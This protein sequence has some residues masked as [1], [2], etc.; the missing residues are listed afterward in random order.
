M[1]LE[2]GVLFGSLIIAFALAGGMPISLDS[3]PFDLIHVIASSLDVCDYVHLS[4]VSQRYHNLLQHE[5]TSRKTL[6]VPFPVYPR[7]LP[8][9]T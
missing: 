5:I 3:L 6:Q 7:S 8:H 9:L 1:S 2:A 4:R